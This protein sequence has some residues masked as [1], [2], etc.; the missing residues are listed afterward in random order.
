MLV[1]SKF[2]YG[3]LFILPLPNHV[4]LF[5]L[6]TWSCGVVYSLSIKPCGVVYSL[7]SKPCGV[8]Y[9]I[10]RHKWCCLRSNPQAMCCCLFAFRFAKPGTLTLTVTILAFTIALPAV[11]FTGTAAYNTKLGYRWSAAV[12]GTW[13][14]PAE[15]YTGKHINTIH[16]GSATLI[17]GFLS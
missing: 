12:T 9:S 17:Y 1:Y 6:S 2:V 4:V 8:V 15:T 10:Q 11:N 5:T 14:F 16:T 7:S 13:I 3:L